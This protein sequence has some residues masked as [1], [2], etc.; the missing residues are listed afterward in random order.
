MDKSPIS[1]QAL[2]SAGKILPSAGLLMS[3]AELENAAWTKLQFWDR[4]PINLDKLRQETTK[5]SVNRIENLPYMKNMVATCLRGCWKYNNRGE[6][7]I[8]Y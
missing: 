6:S 4:H 8:H 7:T 1:W 5:V 3:S 2:I